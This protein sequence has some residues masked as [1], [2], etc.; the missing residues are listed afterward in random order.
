MVLEVVGSVY[1]FEK[2]L[3]G[4]SGKI[5]NSISNP[6]FFFFAL[7]YLLVI[8]FLIIFVKNHIIHHCLSTKSCA[9]VGRGVDISL[10]YIHILYLFK[11]IMF[12]FI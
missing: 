11:R 9:I 6:F 4:H 12:F 3:E 8:T 2:W 7:H 10:I 5:L 1:V